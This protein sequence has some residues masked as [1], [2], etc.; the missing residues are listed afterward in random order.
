ML[1]DLLRLDPLEPALLA[2]VEPELRVTADPAPSGNVA[3]LTIAGRLTSPLPLPAPETRYL[4]QRPFGNS[5]AGL[6]NVSQ[7]SASGAGPYVI[8]AFGRIPPG[9]RAGLRKDRQVI[10]RRTEPDED[11]SCCGTK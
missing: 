4:L 9:D 7:L 11:K 10:Q 3:D 1:R 2:R 5:S 6:P 8:T